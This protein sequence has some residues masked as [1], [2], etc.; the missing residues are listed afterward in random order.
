LPPLGA[1]LVSLDELFATADFVSLHLPSTGNPSPVERR[2][3]RSDEAGHSHHQHG[4]E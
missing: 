4:A 2:P 1:E 3:F